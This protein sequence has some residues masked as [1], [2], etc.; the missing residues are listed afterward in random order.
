[1]VGIKRVM[2][3]GSH[4]PMDEWM[5]GKKATLGQIMA[6]SVHPS[7]I[8]WM[9]TWI[10]DDSNPIKLPFVCLNLVTFIECC[11]LANNNM[12]YEWSKWVKLI[13]T[14]LLTIWR[15]P[16]GETSRMSLGSPPPL[17]RRHI[18]NP[19]T[20]LKVGSMLKNDDTFVREPL[21]IYALLALRK[22]TKDAAHC[23]NLNE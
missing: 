1:M 4:G 8:G 17:P 12:K 20:Y 9:D 5:N 15:N 10:V 6:P 13:Y 23:A 22:Y 19:K 7:L 21:V 2:W 18:S 11:L 16:L 14:V 3:W